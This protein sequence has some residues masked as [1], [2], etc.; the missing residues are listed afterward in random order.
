VLELHRQFHQ[1]SGSA[2]I[3][4]APELTSKYREAA[5]DYLEAHPTSHVASLGRFQG[6]NSGV[7]LFNL[8]RMRASFLY[9]EELTVE[10]MNILLENFMFGGKCCVGDQEW[11]TLIGWEHQFLVHP[12]P[13]A[14]NSIEASVV[15]EESLSY[16]TRVNSKWKSY[17]VCPGE[18]KIIHKIWSLD[19]S[20]K[21]EYAD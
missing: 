12:L 20:I 17:F 1:F 13:C 11:L 4:V 8:T 19:T 3:G 14:Y 6:L 10:R 21:S 18:P 2:L 9:N 5:T 16:N 7:V 15:Q